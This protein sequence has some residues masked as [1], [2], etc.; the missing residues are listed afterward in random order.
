MREKLYWTIEKFSFRY[1]YFMFFDTTPYL[2]D[3]LFI[4]HQVRVWFDS[5]YAKE[6]SPYLAIFCHVRK[7]D[8]PK[9]LAALEDL[10]KSMMLCGHP[11]LKYIC[12]V[13]KEAENE[14][15]NIELRA[16]LRSVGVFLNYFKYNKIMMMKVGLYE[17]EKNRSIY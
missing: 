15:C 11:T 4:R 3:Q 12:T 8:V 13:R 16:V 17:P 6:G 9:F 14:G 7:K 10:K 5:E 1:D 2:A